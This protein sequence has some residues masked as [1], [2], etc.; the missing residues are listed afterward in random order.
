MA[1]IN[2]DS[3]KAFYMPDSFDRSVMTYCTSSPAISNTVASKS[4]A[5]D[6]YT[7]ALNSVGDVSI[8]GLAINDAVDTVKDNI[9][10]LKARIEALEAA[11]ATPTKQESSVST[12]RWRYDRRSFKTLKSCCRTPGLGAL[13]ATN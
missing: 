12:Q 3:D 10:E 8:S 9:G 13:F 4:D 11:M 1:K 5:S 7:Y 2:Y 6:C